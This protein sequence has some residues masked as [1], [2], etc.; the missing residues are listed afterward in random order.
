MFEQGD[1]EGGDAVTK[2]LQKN[3][4][5]QK[6]DLKATVVATSR[7]RSKRKKKKKPASTDI[8][9]EAAAKKR[10]K[11]KIRKARAKERK[12]AAA[13]DVL[14]SSSSAPHPLQ[15]NTDLIPA[16]SITKRLKMKKLSKQMPK[17]DM[18]ETKKAEG[19]LMPNKTPNKRNKYA[20]L[21]DHSRSQPGP[22]KT[23]KR[24]RPSLSEPNPVV[25]SEKCAKLLTKTT[26]AE[27]DHPATIE[28]PVHDPLVL[29]KKRVRTRK[30]FRPEKSVAKAR[31]GTADLPQCKKKLKKKSIDDKSTSKSET[32]SSTAAVK[33]KSDQNKSQEKRESIKGSRSTSNVC[34]PD[35]Q[36]SK[37]EVLREKM[38]NRLNSARF[39]YINEQLYTMPSHDAVAMFREDPEA[40]MIY[41]QGFSGQVSHWPENP[42]DRIIEDVKKKPSKVI[43]DF[44]CGDAKLA[45]SVPN[46]VHSFDLVALNDHVTACDMSKV[47]LQDGSVDIA[48]FCLSL[49][50][51]NLAD[52]IN[53]AWRVLMV[54]GILKVVEVESRFEDIDSFTT[55]VKKL[56]FKLK[57]K[58]SINKM[59]VMM[60]FKKVEAKSKKCPSL[61]L[62]PCIY[63][64]R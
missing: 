13:N 18:P 25:V 40:F 62:K 21:I 16:S 24:K 14:V 37:S 1:W 26:T 30:R 59:F 5:T 43:A 31:S 10:E 32:K 57:F 7:T 53:E 2:N 55:S 61:S 58:V 45:R 52:Y 56:G 19:G 9:E 63:K 50:G 44:G 39:R 27:G 46:T 54:R 60:E 49:M 41:H 35:S 47:P 36:K 22:S 51:S 33:L 20:D 4:F 38:V 42:L 29:N 6:D 48:I 17:P 64:K 3:L 12:T 23:A 28:H 11:M 34:V 15:I 8:S